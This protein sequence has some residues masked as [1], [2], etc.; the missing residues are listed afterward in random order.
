MNHD[1]SPIFVVHFPWA[2]PPLQPRG[3]LMG[4]SGAP[5]A[6]RAKITLRLRRCFGFVSARTQKNLCHR[7]DIDGY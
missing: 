6:E 3:Q 1:T 5:A 7:L 4:A 2:H